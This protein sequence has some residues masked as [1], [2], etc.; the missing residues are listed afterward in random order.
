M[1]TPPHL[2]ALIL[3]LAFA[4]AMLTNPASQAARPEIL[5]REISTTVASDKHGF[6]VENM[7][8]SVS[9]CTNFFQYANGGWVQKNEIPAAYPSWGRF[10]ELGD[11]NQMQLR[12]ILEEAAQKK[13]PAG[14][15]EQKIGDYYTSCMD[16]AG[17]DAA[18]LKPLEPELKMIEAVKDQAGLQAEVARLHMRAVPVMFRIGAG[19]DFKQSTQVIGQIFQSGLGLPDRDYYLKDD[20]KSKDILD[21]YLAHVAKMFA[22]AGDD[23]TMAEAHAKTVVAL[24]TKLAQASMTR[25]ERR[26][27]ENVYHKTTFQ[28]LKELAPNFDWGA[29]FKGIGLVKVGDLNIGQP[30]FIKALSTELN[31]TPIADWKIYLRWQL[32]NAAAPALSKNFVEADFDFKGRTLTGT[33]EILPRWKRCVGATDNALG[34]ALG[35]VYVEKHF[36]PAAKAKAMEMVQNLITALRDD[37]T[38]LSWMSD[39]TRQKATSKLEA[40]VRKIGYPDKWRDYSKLKIARGSYLDNIASVQIFEFHRQLNK[41]AKPVDRTEW[42]M[43]P[44]TVNAY[45]NPTRNEIVFPAGILQSPFYDPKADDAIN[46]GGI[47]AVIGHEM[48]HGFDDSGAKFDASGNLANW[49][50]EEDLKNFQGRAKCVIDQFSSYEVEPGLNQNGKLVV[51]ESIA[52]LGGLT[53]AYAALKKSMEGKPRPANIDGFTPEQRFFL[54]WAQVWAQN[55]RPEYQRLLATIDPHP[56]GRFRVIGPLSNMP[57]FAEA[58]QCKAGDAMVRPPES[59][60]QIW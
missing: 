5:N 16:E 11:Q 50:T 19:Q 44:P 38:T 58:Y 8:T 27:P 55:V 39:A 20:A 12:Q 29:Y 59:R 21:K 37:L 60:C 40:F 34:E 10:N 52:D 33:K 31:A 43:S 25:V 42:G 28:Q 4:V 54:G 26:N 30:E 53:I 56:L 22:L 14:S 46:Y 2:I 41:I 23:A 18:G 47:G 45:Y 7:D 32:L 49:W 17:I 9:A 51:G 13:S 36:P 3:T 15:N 1:K 57:Q 24:E 48:T 6:D 35:Q